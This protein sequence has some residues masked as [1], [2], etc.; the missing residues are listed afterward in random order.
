MCPQSPS[1]SLVWCLSAPPYQSVIAKP[2]NWEPGDHH[3]LRRV[4]KGTQT[5]VSYIFCQL[6]NPFLILLWTTFLAQCSRAQKLILWS[7]LWS[8]EA[9]IAQSPTRVSCPW[10]QVAFLELFLGLKASLSFPRMSWD[11]L[12]RIFFVMDTHS[13]QSPALHLYSV[14]FPEPFPVLS[15]Q[16][17]LYHHQCVSLIKVKCTNET[18]SQIMH[19]W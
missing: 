4:K 13:T 8:F 18:E 19:L 9:K 11:Q 7:Y 2:V 16:Q 5:L 10:G 17:L 6:S 3:L 15:A 1:P 12:L 14:N